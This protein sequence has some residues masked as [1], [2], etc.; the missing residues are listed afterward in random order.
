[1]ILQMGF[2]RGWSY[3]YSDNNKSS[4]GLYLSYI[5]SNII[6][7]LDWACSLSAWFWKQP[8]NLCRN[9]R[10]QNQSYYYRVYSSPV[11]EYYNKFTEKKVL[12]ELENTKVNSNNSRVGDTVRIQYTNTKERIF[13]PKYTDKNTYNTHMYRKLFFLWG[14]LLLVSS[15]LFVVSILLD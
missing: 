4:F 8:R 12:K 10:V 5:I 3:I 15:C 7:I 2:F 11:I 13:D 9:K 14:T 6:C 1:M